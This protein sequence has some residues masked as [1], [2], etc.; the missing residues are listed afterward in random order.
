[1]TQQVKEPMLLLLWFRS[2]LLHI[3][4]GTL[5]VSSNVIVVIREMQINTRSF[6]IHYN[7]KI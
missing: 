3:G 6:L 7:D 5:H 2:L 4:L 1:M